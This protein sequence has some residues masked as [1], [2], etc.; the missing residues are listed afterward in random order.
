MTVLSWQRQ[1]AERHNR[2]WT[3]RQGLFWKQQVL[4]RPRGSS[5]EQ[6]LLLLGFL[7]A[8]CFS[9]MSTKNLQTL[10][11]VVLYILVNNLISYLDVTSSSHC[12]DQ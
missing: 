2:L 9:V 8:V 3:N 5:P 7:V 6:A 10:C 1:V 12:T 4:P 11:S